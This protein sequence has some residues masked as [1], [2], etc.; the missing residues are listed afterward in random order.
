MQLGSALS[1]GLID[2]VGA[3]GTAWLR[4]VM[5]AL[6]FLAISR[7]PIKKIR[8]QDVPVLIGLGVTTGIMTM[9]FLAAI[10]NIPL[11]TS[12][13]IEFL[14]PLTVA[15]F[16]SKKARLLIWPALAL[17]GVVLLTEPWNGEI[18]L[19]G[20]GFALLSGVAWGTYIVLTQRV[21]D[22]FDGIS[23]LSITIPIAAIVSAFIGVPQAW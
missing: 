7:P 13:A 8:K 5:G 10:E 1:I 14:G 15:S 6:I 22:R 23:G 16:T 18:N 17:I 12:V 20:I 11:G 4:L 19:L 21:G 9:A 3:A 2:Q